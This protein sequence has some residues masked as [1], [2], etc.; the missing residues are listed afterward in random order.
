MQH[1]NPFSSEMLYIFAF[2]PTK[3]PQEISYEY[4]NQQN[5]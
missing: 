3:S 2:E 1:I 4:A 5:Q